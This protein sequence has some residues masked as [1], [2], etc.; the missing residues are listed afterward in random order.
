M[1][2]GVDPA[3]RVEAHEDGVVKPS[4]EVNPIECNISDVQGVDHQQ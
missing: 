4:D 3:V 2:G 1:I